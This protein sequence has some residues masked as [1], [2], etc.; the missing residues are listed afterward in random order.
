MSE[1]SPILGLPYIQPAQ[2]Q[3]HVT[4]NEAITI[5]E[6][7][8]QL[9]VKDHTLE[10]PPSGAGRGD[11]YL[12]PA[13]ANGAWGS[14]A[15][16][17]AVWNGSS[18]TFVSP[19]IGWQAFSE[20]GGLSIQFNGATWQVDDDH[21]TVE[22]VGVNSTADSTNRLSVASDATL[23]NHVGGGHQLKLNKS[24]VIDTASLLFQTN[25]SGRAEMGTTGSDNFEIKIT[26]DG[27][28]WLTSFSFD[29][30]TGLVS[31][32]AVQ[33]AADDDTAG[34]LARVDYVYGKS[35]LL[36]PVSETA[37]LPTGG[38]IERGEN[39]NG[40]FVR[41]ADGTQICWSPEFVADADLAAGAIFRSPPVDWTFPLA[42]FEEPALSQGRQNH[43]TDYWT[44]PGLATS[45][46]ATG[47]AMSYRQ[48]NSRTINLVAFGRWY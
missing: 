28:T 40:E 32:D 26:E 25:W 15:G 2:A 19:Q 18:W 37:G 34:K 43:S 35:N 38:V 1:E 3:K 7:A 4:H 9:S 41:F 42:F 5:L 31:G 17:V 8:I 13:G 24:S 44:V 30:G 46:T 29:G 27:S 12:I 33:S 11:R 10:T 47:C 36:A 6:A 48:I 22:T 16:D 14:D 21:L 39:A 20:Q 45:T 23:L